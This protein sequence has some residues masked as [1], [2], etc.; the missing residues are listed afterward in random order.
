MHGAKRVSTV[1]PMKKPLNKKEK[2][3]MKNVAKVKFHF[4]IENFKTEK[5]IRRRW[6]ERALPPRRKQT[7]ARR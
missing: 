7:A 1:S 4:S 2:I 5:Y 6:L 3:A